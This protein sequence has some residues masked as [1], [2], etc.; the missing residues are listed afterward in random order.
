[1]IELEEGAER[2]KALADW[3]G[4]ERTVWV[5]VGNCDKV[6]AI[7]NEDLDREREDK[8]SSVHFMRFQLSDEMVAAA[9]AGE[10]ISAGIDLAQYTQLAMPLD[11][12][13]QNALRADLRCS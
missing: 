5:K 8:T 3:I 4:I 7:C 11:A 1:M 2:Q 12:R 9:C 6:Y 10:P 13:F